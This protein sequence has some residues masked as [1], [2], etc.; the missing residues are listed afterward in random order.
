ME[1]ISQPGSIDLINGY[2]ARKSCI[3]N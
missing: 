3:V 1:N 2:S